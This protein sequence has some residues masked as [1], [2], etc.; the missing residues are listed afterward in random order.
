MTP[1]DARERIRD[2]SFPK[3]LVQVFQL[4]VGTIVVGL[5]LYVRFIGLE[6]DQQVLAQRVADNSAIV[7][8]LRT[9]NDEMKLMQREIFVTQK[10]MIEDL[11]Y[12]KEKVR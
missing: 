11:Q 6:K 2:F 3:W 1:D 4:T 8:E 12:I 9:D 10:R 5:A 7:H